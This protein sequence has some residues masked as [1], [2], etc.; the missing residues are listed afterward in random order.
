MRADKNSSRRRCELQQD[1]HDFQ[2]RLRP[3]YPSWSRPRSH[4]SATG[5]RNQ[6]PPNPTRERNGKPTQ[7]APRLHQSD[8]SHTLV[9]PIPA[10][11]P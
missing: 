1:E 8:R 3:G 4:W 7:A 6:Q 9:R 10:G 11:A 2:K 5:P